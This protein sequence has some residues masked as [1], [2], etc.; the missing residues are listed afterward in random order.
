MN[1][2]LPLGEM[3]SDEPPIDCDFGVL[4]LDDD[5]ETEPSSAS[6]DDEWQKVLVWL[7]LLGAV[8]LLL[9]FVSRTKERVVHVE[10]TNA[11]EVT[12]R[13]IEIFGF[14]R[15]NVESNKLE[16]TWIGVNAVDLRV[17]EDDE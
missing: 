16:T 3:L 7:I 10:G 5:I 2:V 11:V 17:V 8:V 13:R 1:D 12:N 14:E 4:S 6:G 9:F 15:M